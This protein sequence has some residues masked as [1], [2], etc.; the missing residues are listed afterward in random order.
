MIDFGSENRPPLTRS[1]SGIVGS[2]IVRLQFKTSIA[3][4]YRSIMNVVNKLVTMNF[5]KR[6]SHM[7]YR[8][9]R[10]IDTD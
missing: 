4:S 2:A 9:A 1:L 10:H 3:A 7:D 6:T 5:R 8:R